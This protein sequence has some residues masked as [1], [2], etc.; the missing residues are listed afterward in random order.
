MTDVSET[1]ETKPEVQKFQ[2]GDEVIV[3]RGLDRDKSG[4]ILGVDE[5]KA[6]YAISYED[7]SFGIQ[8][9]VNV[10][11]PTVGAVSVGRVATIV[12]GWY[13]DDNV[14]ERALIQDL[15]DGL[16]G[17]EKAWKAATA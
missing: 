10:K 1:T 5:A 13:N 3:M 6:Q 7:G 12:A 15:K 9:F 14:A 8:N 2:K 16:P 4:T 11:A 17:F